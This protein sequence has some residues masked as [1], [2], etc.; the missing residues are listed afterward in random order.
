MNVTIAD[1]K[2]HFKIDW[3]SLLVGW[4]GFGNHR[5]FLTLLEL[6]QFVLEKLDTTPVPKI[7]QLIPFLDAEADQV[8][9]QL[10]KL[11]S[12]NEVDFDVAVR[13]WVV[14]LLEKKLR[15][16][17]SDP[18]YGLIE[19]TEFWTDVSFPSDCPHLVQGKDSALSPQRYYTKDNYAQELDRHTKW[20]ENEICLIRELEKKINE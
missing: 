20:I 17:P 14:C 5:R 6:K 18:L 1:L 4:R 15:G 12:K 8:D 9:L 3:T 10:V 11:A 16:L 7:D 13:K 19:L 2:Q